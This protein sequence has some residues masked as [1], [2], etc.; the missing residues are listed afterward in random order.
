MN[1][2]AKIFTFNLPDRFL[3]I[4]FFSNFPSSRPGDKRECAC[5]FVWRKRERV[6]SLSRHKYARAHTS[7]YAFNINGLVDAECAGVVS[8]AWQRK[9]VLRW[10]WF[11]AS[12]TRQLPMRRFLI[13]KNVKCFVVCDF[14]PRRHLLPCHALAWPT[15]AI[16]FAAIIC[17]SRIRWY[18]C[19]NRL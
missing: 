18:T 19:R 14:F 10:V 2:P 1:F 15:Y 8:C 13:D 6:A 11:V 9:I 5:V 16:H 12:S 4:Q 3:C 7:T 17:T